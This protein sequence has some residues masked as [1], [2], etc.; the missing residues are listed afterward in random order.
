LPVFPPQFE[1]ADG[2]IRQYCHDSAAEKA[3][4]KKCPKY[5]FKLQ[6]SHGITKISKPPP[7]GKPHGF[8]PAVGFAEYLAQDFMLGLP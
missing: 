7:Q 5:A 6:F 2:D 8:A 4:A 3:A 1:Q